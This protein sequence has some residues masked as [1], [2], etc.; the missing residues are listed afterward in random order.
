MYKRQVVVVVIF[1][2]V[3]V[4]LTVVVGDSSI[5]Y[6]V[7]CIASS[8]FTMRYQS[9]IQNV[10]LNLVSFGPQNWRKVGPEC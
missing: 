4:L 10:Y 7:V 8:C 6:T 5:I 2:V 9:V 3:V 1:V